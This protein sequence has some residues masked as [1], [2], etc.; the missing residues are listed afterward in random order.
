[1]RERGLIKQF[2]FKVLAFLCFGFSFVIYSQEKESP[3]PFMN[4]GYNHLC[5]SRDSSNFLKLYKKL[6]DLKTKK[7]NR[8]AIAHFGGSHVQ[9][10]TWS[11]TFVNNFQKDF[12]TVGGGYF[13]FPYKI[14]K[15]NGQ[16]FATTFSNGNW[17]RFRAIGQDFCSPLG[18][19][20]LSISTHDSVTN[21]GV[22]LTKKAICKSFSSIKVYHN[23]TD[24]F[25]F[26][27]DSLHNFQ[28][29]RTDFKDQGYTLLNFE[30]PVDSINFKLLRKDE[31]HQDFML[32]GF[33][34]DNELQPGF[35]FA[36]LGA[37]GAASGSF[38]RC[39]DLSSQFSSLNADLV[40]ISLGVNDTQSKNFEREE[41]IENYDSL[42]TVLKKA[43]P[44][45]A[46][47]LTTTTDN[48]IKRKTSNKR[49]IVARDAMFELM[50]KHNI[51]VWDLFSVMGGYK[52]MV[53]W[54]KAGLAGRD[55]VHF[56]PKGYVLLGNLMYEAFNKS[57]N[58][59]QN[60]IN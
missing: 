49:T 36:G 31:A 33:S 54:Q 8:I 23:F 46:I 4:M 3:Y 59:N 10:G 50:E 38:L 42:I 16:A 15:T 9:A 60:H 2:K 14:A 22:A 40:I 17:K 1:M 11:S 51:A 45:V 24:G 34:L 53:K 13:V 5:F 19:S 44:D 30:L 39:L 28:P 32:F 6:D 48:F 25:E 26:A 18:M 47:I 57:Y 55:R 27:V 21:F 37:N 43:N 58:A 35:Y 52:S 41:Y 12:K 56:S 7:N 20:A 29:I